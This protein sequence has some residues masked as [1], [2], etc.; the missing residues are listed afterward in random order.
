MTGDARIREI[1]VAGAG[2]VG[3]SAAAMLK[4]RIPG[5]AV[6]LVGTAPADALAERVGSTLP[7]INGFHGDLGL[8]EAEAMRATGASFRLGTLFEGWSD[9]C[10]PYVHAYGEYGRPFGTA[11]FHH[12]WVRAARAGRA[13]PFDRH[14]PAATLA[15]AG[16]F[17]HPQ[18]EDGAP[19]AGFE[20]GLNLDP[21]R[22]REMMRGYALHLGVIE[23]AA[24]VRG[25]RIAGET[26]FVEALVLEDGE[27]SGELFVDCTGHAA[28]IRSQLDDRFEDW[29]RW[30]PCDRVLLADGPGAA[31]PPPLDTAAAHPAGWG[32]RSACRAR[33][34]HGLV[35]ASAHLADDRAAD[36]LSA[37]AGAACGAPVAVRAGRRS[38]PWLR[39]CVAIGE[40]AVAVEPLEWTNL[41][42]AHSALDRLVAKLPGRDCAAVELWTTTARARRKATACGISSCSIMRFPSGRRHSGALPPPRPC[43]ARS[44]TRSGCSASAGGFRSMRKRRFRGMAG[45]RS[46]S[47]RARFRAASIR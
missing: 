30:L 42:L 24:A 14:S 35:Y 13:A 5:V 12:H 31:D 20:Y 38:Q 32:W 3:W 16:R 15:R 1:V 6:T 27:V 23:R 19:L 7:S 11:S 18:G 26:G 28:Q 21:A 36:L 4:R 33:T 46:C 39:N 47:G 10:P 40:A 8:D 9:A 41:H 17:V 37:A 25:V 34:S 43:R 45:R 44:S 22:Y 29:G 2:L